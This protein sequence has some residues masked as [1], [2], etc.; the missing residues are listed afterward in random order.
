MKFTAVAPSNIAFIKYW[1]KKDEV[2]R[3]PENGSISFN[4]SKVLT[5][6]TVEFNPNFVKDK[7]VINGKEIK[8]EGEKVIKHLD[9]IRSLAKLRSKAKVVSF[10][11]FPASVGLSSSASGFAALTTAAAKA[12]GLNLSEKQ[13]SVLSRQGSGSS[14]RSIPD[15]WVEW[16]NGN[17]SET[18]YARSIFPAGWWKILDIAVVVSSDKKEISSTEGQK[19]A[20]NSPFYQSR[21]KNI[22]KKIKEIKKAIKLRDFKAFGGISEAEALELHAIM[23]TSWPALLYWTSGTLKLI[24]LVQKWRNQGLPVYFTLNTGQTVHLIV[25][26]KNKNKVLKKLKGQNFIRKVI[27]N[28]PGLG[29]R[30]INKHLF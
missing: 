23:I 2:L 13:L 16:L 10:N 7:V 1:G 12:A 29:A 21:L 9:R 24:K 8:E 14:C 26:E 30:I 25:E 6:T 17:T 3:L 20:N 15:G 27:V 11:N 19:S 5:T 18:S 28:R 22:N 4:L